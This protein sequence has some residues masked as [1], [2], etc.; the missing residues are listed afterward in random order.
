MIEIKKQVQDLLD[1]GV[2]R[3]SSSP[4]GSLIVMVTK[5]DDTWR[6][7][8]NYRALNKITVKN[9]YPHPRIDDLLDQLKNVVYLTKLDLHSEY[10]QIR[11]AE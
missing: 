3:P 8:V 5:K 9:R 7:C 4:C 6:M 10:H 1:Q 2:I 11:V